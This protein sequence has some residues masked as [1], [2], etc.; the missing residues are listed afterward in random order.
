MLSDHAD[1]LCKLLLAQ[2]CLMAQNHRACILNLILVELA[3]AHH[4][5]LASLRINNGCEAVKLKL[6][7]V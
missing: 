7:D 1:N 3:E 2:S 4:H 5:G 6:L